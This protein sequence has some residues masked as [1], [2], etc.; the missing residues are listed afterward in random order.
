ME[1]RYCTDEMKTFTHLLSNMKYLLLLL[2]LMP[3][4]W[5]EPMQ[6][7]DDR[8]VTQKKHTPY[9]LYLT[10]FEAFNMK[11][12]LG[13]DVLLVDV[14]TRVELKY[15]GAT[16]LMDANIPIRFIHPDFS[17]SD[18]SATYRTI[19]NDHFTEDFEK[20]LKIKG[21]DKNTPIILMCQSGSRVPV[22]AETL[23]EAGFKKVYSQ[24]QGFEGIKAKHGTFK[25]QRL[26]DGWKNAG[27]PW[28]YHLN[29]DAMYFNFDSSQKQES[30]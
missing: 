22:A 16:E 25:G 9:G 7:A 3:P 1:K 19:G 2:T 18:K 26:I 24:Y 14:R 12:Q 21:K 27:L 29:K 17:W 20:L 6:A 28:S 8:D 4:C 11:Q 10:P 15:V 13:D 23:H 30:H 5:S